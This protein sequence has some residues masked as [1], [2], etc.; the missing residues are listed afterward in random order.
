MV[1]PGN[2]LREGAV[3]ISVPARME[4]RLVRQV[5]SLFKKSARKA[6]LRAPA[7]ADD[8]KNADIHRALLDFHLLLR[9][10]RLYEKNHPQRIATLN[11]TYESFHRAVLRDK[12]EILVERDG[13]AVPRLGKANLPDARGEMQA[14]SGVLQQAGIRRLLF[15]SSFHWRN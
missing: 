3:P 15:T 4:K 9:C 10:E 13:L 12:L 14:L 5:P 8:R 11:A 7:I 2:P 6:E 1:R